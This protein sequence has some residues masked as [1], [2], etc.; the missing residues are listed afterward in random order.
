MLPEASQSNLAFTPMRVDLVLLGD[1]DDVAWPLGDVHRTASTPAALST[2]QRQLCELAPDVQGVLLWD[3]SLAPPCS[4]TVVRLMSEPGHCWHAGPLLQAAD[5]PRALFWTN[6]VS[7][8]RLDPQVEGGASW[9]VSFRACLLRRELWNGSAAFLESFETLEAMALCAGLTWTR[10]GKMLRYSPSLLK[11]KATHWPSPSLRDEA[12]FARMHHSRGW[13]LWSS[14]LESVARRADVSEAFA[15]LRIALAVAPQT[16]EGLASNAP[17]SS[18]PDEINAKVTVVIPT[19][20]REPYLRSTL[21]Q[22]REQTI[23]PHQVIVVDQTNAAERPTTLET[24]F[25]DL[26]LKVLVL[27]APGQSTARNLAIAG[28]TGEWILLLDDDIEFG[29]KLIEDHLRCIAHHGAHA[30]CGNLVEDRS[31]MARMSQGHP[32]MSDVF[33]G[34][35]TLVQRDFLVA[36][37]GFDGIY[38]HGI[39]ADGDVGCR[40]RVR[41]CFAV[42]SPAIAVFHHRAPRGGLRTHKARV[43]TYGTTRRSLTQRHFMTRTEVYLALRHFGESAMRMELA[44]RTLTT[45]RG[46]GSL[47]FMCAKAVIG[48]C[49]F[50]H[51]LVRHHRVVREGRALFKSGPIL[52]AVQADHPPANAGGV[53]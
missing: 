16:V 33:P 18:Y 23:R 43:H 10:A 44:L 38:D 50:P 49:Q 48:L 7:L 27:D 28:A 19:I 29:P 3:P 34:S 5:A 24:D 47:L 46:H 8:L 20:D 35:N 11:R 39:R 1:A 30:S 2:L 52:M 6:P 21:A 36:I 15:A 12:R 51:T 17:M 26:P 53:G 40:L 25:N 31:L 13:A 42:F 32:V 14:A 41:G 22:L 9:R 4:E 37:R 45:M